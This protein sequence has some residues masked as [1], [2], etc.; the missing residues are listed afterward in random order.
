GCYY[1]D[2]RNR[3]FSVT[4]GDYSPESMTPALCAAKCG[5]FQ[6]D[7]AALTFGKFCFCA[8]TLPVSGVVSDINCATPCSGNITVT[9]GAADY[10]DVYS[11]SPPIIGLELTA[12][13]SLSNGISVV[14]VGDVVSFSASYKSSGAGLTFQLDYGDGAGRT[15]KNDTDMWSQRFYTPGQYQITLSGNDLIDSLVEKQAT[16]TVMVEA[17]V[18]NVSLTCQDFMASFEEGKCDLVI[19]GG[20]NLQITHTVDG[21]PYTSFYIAE[22]PTYTAGPDIPR[23]G[24]NIVAG[25]TSGNI[26]VMPRSEFEHSGTLIGFEYFGES[27]GNVNFYVFSPTCGDYCFD[28]NNCNPT[29]E[30]LK[31]RTCSGG[32]QYCTA[33][34]KCFNGGTCPALPVRYDGSQRTAL[35]Q[36]AIITHSISAGYGYFEL[37]L[38]QYDIAVSPGYIIG[39]QTAGGKLSAIT[40]ANDIS[41]LSTNDIAATGAAT[42]LNKRHM[43]RAVSSAGS[44]AIIPYTFSTTGVKTVS[45]TITNTVTSDSQTVTDTISVIEGIDKAV[46]DIPTYIEKGVDVSFQLE[47]HTGTNVTYWWDFGDLTEINT[48]DAVHLKQYATVGEFNVTVMAF[49]PMSSKTNYKTIIVQERIVGLDL[50]GQF[51]VVNEITSIQVAMTTGTHY[52]C[53]WT[54]DGTSLG[55][56]SDV[57]TPPNSYYNITFTLD[58]TYTISTTCTNNLNSMA[59]SVQITAQRRITGLQLIN[60]GALLNQQYKVRFRWSDGSN[61]Q[62][63]LQFN[64]ATKSL[65]VDNFLLEVETIQTFPAESSPTTYPLNITAYNLVSNEQIVTNFGIESEIVNPIPTIDNNLPLG[66]K[67][68]AKGDILSFG[69]DAS[70]GTN[71][72]VKWEHWN[73]ANSYTVVNDVTI[74]TWTTTQSESITFNDL[75][76]HNV[77]L[78]I[79]NAYSSNV[80][81][82]RILAIAPVENMLIDSISATLFVPPAD[83][84]VSFTQSPTTIPPNEAKIVIDFGDGTTAQTLD[85]DLAMSIPYQYRVDGTFTISANISNVVSSQVVTQTVDIVEA[86]DALEIAPEPAHAPKGDPVDVR[87]K[88]RRGGT[89]SKLRLKWDMGAG[90][91]A[92]QDRTGASPDGYDSKFH[93]FN[94]LGNHVLRVT[95]QSALETKETT[96]T[97]TC[98]EKVTSAFTFST[99]YPK[100]FASGGT[101]TFDLQYNGVI[102]T[103]AYITFDY[104]D[105][106]SS[107]AL[108]LSSYITISGGSH[109]FSHTYTSDGDYVTTFQIYNLVSSETIQIPSGA[110]LDFVNL[111][112]V[113]KWKPFVPL[114]GPDLDG[115]GASNDIFPQ[116]RPVRFLMSRTQGTLIYYNVI[117]TGPDVI[118]CNKTDPDVVEVDFSTAK[119][120]TYSVDIT[121]INPLFSRTISRTI[122]IMEPV[123]GITIDDGGIHAAAYALKKFNM[124]FTYVGSDSC[125]VVDFGDDRGLK[126]YGSSAVCAANPQSSSAVYIS[127]ITTNRIEIDHTYIAMG[128]FIVSAN[129]FNSYS[130][131]TANFTHVISTVDCSQPRLGIKNRKENFYD[132]QKFVKSLRLNIVGVTDINCAHTLNNEKRWTLFKVDTNTG[133]ETDEINIT[134]LSSSKK[135]ALSLPPLYLEYGLYKAVYFIVMDPGQFQSNETFSTSVDHFVEII[136]SPL[137]VRIFSGGTTK[138]NRGYGIQVTIEPVLYSEDPDLASNVPQNFDNFTWFCREK[139]ETFPSPLPSPQTP[140]TDAQ[141]ATNP[142]DNGG[143]FRKG[144]GQ[145]DEM[146]GSLTFSTT[147]MKINSTYVF[148]VEGYKGN[149]MSRTSAELLILD[150]TPPELEISCGPH[151]CLPDTDGQL[152]RPSARLSLTV[153]CTAECS[154]QLSYQWIIR[155]ENHQ[156]QNNLEEIV[157]LGNY[158][159]GVNSDN[160]AVS[161]DLFDQKPNVLRYEVEVIATRI[162]TSDWGMAQMKLRINSP[163]SGGSCTV[164]PLVGEALNDN[165]TVSCPGWSDTDGIKLYSVYTMVSGDSLQ[166]QVIYGELTSYTVQLQVGPDYDDYNTTVYVRIT[167]VHD[168]ATVVKAG[169][170]QVKPMSATAIEAKFTAMTTELADNLDEEI[171]KGDTIGLNELAAT[172]A[173]LINGASKNLS[174]AYAGIDVASTHVSTGMGVN[175]DN[176]QGAFD[177]S[178]S[179]YEKEKIYQE[180]RDINVKIVAQITEALN[181][182]TLG[183]MSSCALTASTLAQLTIYAENCAR[184]CQ[185]SVADVAENIA[186]TIPQLAEEGSTLEEVTV[187]ATGIISTLSNI[188]QASNVNF[189]DPSNTDKKDVEDKTFYDSDWE[190]DQEGIPFDVPNLEQGTDEL[191]R[192]TNKEYQI[193]TGKRTEGIFASALQSLRG[194]LMKMKVDGE[195][196]TVISTPSIV[197]SFEKNQAQKVAS[198]AIALG[199][200]GSVALPDWCSMQSG[201]CNPDASVM[202][203]ASY[204]TFFPNAHTSNAQELSPYSGALNIDLFGDD[205]NAISVTGASDPISLTIPLDRNM[206]TPETDE[207]TPYIPD[208]DSEHYFYQTTTITASRS[209]IQEVFRGVKIGVQLLVLVKLGTIQNINQ[210]FDSVC[211]IPH[212]MVYDGQYGNTADHPDPYSCFMDSDEVNG[213][214]GEVSFAIRQMQPGEHDRYISK[215]HVPTSFPKGSGEFS[216]NYTS[217]FISAGCKYYDETAQDWAT[218]GCKVSPYTNDK[219]VRCECT[220]L[221]TFAGGWVVVPNTIDWNFVFSN[222]DFYKNP[223]LYITQIIIIVVYLIAVIWARRQD[224]LDVEKLGLTPL[225][226]NDKKDHYYYEIVVVT[227]MRRNAGSDSKVSFILAGENDETE[228][229]ELVDKK[230]KILRRGAVDGFLMAVSKPLGQLTYLHLWHDNSGKGKFASWYMRSIVVRDVQTNDKIIPVAGKE[231]MTEFSHLFSEKTTKSL[232][233]GHLWFSVVA[234]PPQSRFTRVQRVSCCL[235]LL[236]MTMVTNA[237]FYETAENTDANNTFTFGPFALTPEQIYIGVVSNLIVFP[238]NFLVVL[239][240]RKSRPRKKRPSRVL[241]ALKET[242]KPATSVTDINPTLKASQS[243]CPTPQILDKNRPDTFD[244]TSTNLVFLTAI[245]F[246]LIIK[247]PGGDD[248]EEAEDEEN[249]QLQ[250]DEELLHNNEGEVFSFTKPRKAAY[251]PPDPSLLQ[252]AREVRMKEIKM[253]AVVREIVFYA[254]FLWILMV[255]SYRNRSYNSFLYKQSLDKVFIA[256]NDTRHHYMKIKN[257]NDFWVW[258]KSGLIT[259]LRASVWYNDDQPLFMRGYINDKQSRIMG[260][261]TMRQLRIRPGGTCKIP[262]DMQ[263]VISECND[264]YDIDEQDEGTYRAGWL[265]LTGNSSVDEDREEYKYL[266]AKSLDGYPYFGTMAVYGGGG[267]IVRLRGNTTVLYDKLDQLQREGW[268]DKY[269][270]AVFIEF[271][272][273]NPGVN[274]FGISTLLLEV[275]PSQGFF[276]AYRFEP[277]MLLPYM[278]SV[279][280]FQIACE[281]IYLLFTLVFT[282]QLLRG[283]IREKKEFFRE[284]WNL[285]DIGICAM[286]ITAIVIYFYR[287]FETNRLTERFKISHGNEYMKFQYVGYWSEL[288]SY[289]IGWLV[290]FA[291]LKFL[292]LLRFNKRMSLLAS[293]LKSSAKDLMHFSVIFNIIFMAFIQLFYLVYAANITSFKTFVSS[294]ESGIVMMMGKFDIYE[295]IAVEP[296]MTQIF[297]FGYVVTI[298][299]ITVNMFLS[300]LNETF[301]SVRSDIAK[302]CNDYEIV[303]F[304]MNRFKMWT[305]LGTPDTNAMKPDVVKGGE[306]GER[307]VEEFPER[308]DRLLHSISYM[309]M[310]KDRLDTL[311]EMNSGK[312]RMKAMGMGMSHPPPAVSRKYQQPPNKMTMVHTNY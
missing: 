207:I 144:P 2:K 169:I 291:S 130:T 304:M 28:T 213:Y 123:E 183:T 147:N 292:K 96:Y 290:F 109:I 277:V 208:R 306:N 141:L 162:G 190:T 65:T 140:Y 273:Y 191:L 37:D 271:T 12:T 9:C 280:L 179:T 29:C 75:G 103:D 187:A 241:E 115:Y 10:A 20:T 230:R 134:A 289:I 23:T 205:G 4:P 237:M 156:W 217:Q 211:M 70:S 275:L 124:S 176:R 153:N 243:S 146:T 54:Q 312:A 193:N 166:R 5:A 83:I 121:A 194:T 228:V 145:I 24:A 100:D 287:L 72:N 269:T 258:A 296:I 259:G 114:N 131:A 178:Q 25:D 225:A 59:S 253:W 60:T 260:Y 40:T 263:S 3:H 86:I 220:H 192:I 110:Y 171:A 87:V 31:Q 311:L 15:N 293:T 49:N 102:P 232:S 181:T 32:D 189:D 278:D 80:Y 300:I 77:T 180:K 42:L 92:Y 274:L 231:Q 265:P 248:D 7:Y 283:L 26:I 214:T 48:T 16:T 234:R 294:C 128:T 119:P 295:M 120:G 17:K 58:G 270:R 139:S 61:P 117:A 163:P 148:E 47:P 288:F 149:R 93:T 157:D 106:T 201:S 133:E 71:V 246:S 188:V 200:E 264:A 84:I 199:D 165:F 195:K 222:M 204:T 43:L 62:F 216:T 223:T 297:I 18:K 196:P 99:N 310:E 41:D 285:V 272:G 95:A 182:I 202:I 44:A 152:I 21:T 97:I 262:K 173:S 154:G 143:C 164:S 282:I 35:T 284:F 74:A 212:R 242:S 155:R 30:G 142:P 244:V 286:S 206:P 138:V 238:I 203:Q 305:G 132:P 19:L 56:T 81:Q 266:T 45:V 112:A 308:I 122:Q 52:T 69:I 91:G 137:V 79:Q 82:Y 22:P 14:H 268:V 255:I 267:Y 172:L 227:G 309:Y 118:V 127:D 101:L 34:G 239:L 210:D 105:G 251:R 233:D 67:A 78:T 90:Y 64:G 73:P 135:A 252:K 36:E 229:R 240:F 116:D 198:K 224:K 11:S 167:D 215:S 175:Y 160:I 256:T 177:I 113:A 279:M 33:S 218:S 161:T 281:I 68:V 66:Y 51:A 126:A 13:P 257:Q 226:D 236:F 303:D 27:A 159:D 302:Q 98:Q 219:T 247:N 174:A 245:F 38:T 57:V 299:F 85:F 89:G 125:V 108:S 88:L 53:D 249:A 197:I 170:I 261:A 221:T 46:I 94:T 235:C 104:G 63:S 55:S 8:S 250:Q 276:P 39:Y 168:A 254:F 129:G 76:Y 151:L 185:E 307:E 1:E 184:P 6:Y 186:L 209:S 50:I 298:T 111:Q 136:E 301:S 158:V 150:G 107:G